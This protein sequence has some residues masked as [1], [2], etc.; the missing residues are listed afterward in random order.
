MSNEQDNTALVAIVIALIAFFVTTAQL[1]QALFGTAEGYRRCQSSVIGG[2]ATK[3]KRVWRWSEFRFETIF[4]TPNIHLYSVT[5]EQRPIH[6]GAFIEG[7]PSSRRETYADEVSLSGT[8]GLREFNGHSEATDDLASWLFLLSMLHHFQFFYFSDTT[9]GR[10][11]R[12]NLNDSWALAGKMTCPAITFR[13][14]SWD[15]MPPD[16]VRP[17]AT[18]NV[19][20]ILALA[21]RLGMRWKEVRPDDGVMRAEGNGQSITSTTVRGFG[22]LLQYTFDPG[23]TEEKIRTLDI[24]R[25]LTIPSRETDML[26]FQI[27]SGSRDLYLPDFTFDKSN[28]VP[29]VMLVMNQLGISRDVQDMYADYGQRSGCFH[30]FSDLIGMVTPFLP[31]PGSSV[32]QVFT[33]YPEV[34]DSPTNWWE[35]FVVYHKR[36][37][38]FVDEQRKGGDLS[39][40]MKWVLERFEYMR[41]TYPWDQ[42]PSWEAESANS[43]I[44][45]GRSIRFLNDLRNIWSG[46]MTYFRML[47]KQK[48][49][50]YIDLVGAHIAQAVYYPDLAG[51]KI[52]AGTNKRYDL[53]AGR[54]KRVAEAMHIYVDQIPK[55]IEFMKEKGFDTDSVVRKA[56]WT[57]ILKAMCWHRSVAFIE[58]QR[59]YSVPS[60]FH[61]SR[62]PVYIA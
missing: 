24:M 10:S 40:Q 57:S 42:C 49:F 17:F 15:F 25:T 3:T 35:G 18:S 46:T 53:G 23:I 20:D 2:W 14:R 58:I 44:K 32:V 27:V 8:A 50:R 30:G 9:Y 31:L 7:S 29:A 36:L 22:L 37:L 62:I 48:G 4:T 34:Y 21:H 11:P 43:Q 45:N 41:S 54:S 19:G 51:A 5:D 33:P 16:I 13:T 52:K 47:Q 38:E 12:F 1:L 59:G 39:V 6:L 60:S 61:G 55:V 26:G 28:S 56:W